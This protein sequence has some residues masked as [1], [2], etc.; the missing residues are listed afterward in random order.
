MD[1]LISISKQKHQKNAEL[2]AVG[3]FYWP[4]HDITEKII[5]LER[6]LFLK[7]LE[8]YDDI[9]RPIGSKEAWPIS[10]IWLAA[11]EDPQKSWSLDNTRLFTECARQ[12]SA[13]AVYLFNAVK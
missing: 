2:H 6:G 3:R 4:P 5:N 11:S 10:E 1:N 8:N 13:S 12:P 7:L 9:L